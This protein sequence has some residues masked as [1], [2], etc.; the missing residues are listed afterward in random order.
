MLR[1]QLRGA[2]FGRRVIAILMGYWSRNFFAS[3]KP[4]PR[5]PRRA[6]AARAASVKLDRQ[7][8]LLRGNAVGRGFHSDPKCSLQM[9]RV[10]TLTP[11]VRGVRYY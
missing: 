10:F 3:E 8:T 7:M 2:Y 6:A 9:F 4:I 1:S 11:N 5:R